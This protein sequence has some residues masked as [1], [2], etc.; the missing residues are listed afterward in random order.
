MDATGYENI[1]MSGTIW[2]LTRPEIE[3]SI[4]EIVDFTELGEYLDVPVRTYSNGMMLRLAFAVA[5][6]RNPEIMLIDEVIGVGDKK[7]FAK[8]FARL[9]RVVERSQILFVASHADDILRVLCNKA[10]W[11][12][13]GNLMKYG[14]FESTLAAYRGSDSNETMSIPTLLPKVRAPVS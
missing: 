12:E 1:R 14:D 7:F 2:G 10:I 13:H 8:A 5:T 6:V 3:S 4:P 9:Q 11:L